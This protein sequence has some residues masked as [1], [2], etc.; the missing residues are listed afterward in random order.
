[1]IIANPIY[2]I[3]FKYL[4]EDLDIVRGL[5]SAILKEEIISLQ[6][7]PQETIMEIADQSI[8]IFK[9][10]FKALIK[11]P[12][13]PPKKV[14]LEL[15]KAKHLFDIMRFRRYLGDNYRKQ[16]PVVNEPESP[17]GPPLEIVTIYFLGFK[18]E[19]VT[20]PVLKVGHR[21]EDAISGQTL[22]GSIRE[23]FVN[24][25][26]HES[27]VIQIPRLEVRLRNHLE[28]VLQVFCQ[29]D[30]MEDEHKIN[31]RQDP[32]NPLA[33]KMVER[34]NRAVSTEEVRRVMDLE[35]DL[36]R[37]FFRLLTEG[38]LKAEKE[39]KEKAEKNTQKLVD[40]A[41]K[42]AKKQAKEEA[43]EEAKKEAKKEVDAAEK[44]A[45][46]AIKANEDAQSKIIELQKRLD[47]LTNKHAI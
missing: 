18:L 15:Q 45:E 47:D 21:Y 40:E 28:E 23:E 4:L 3:V 14:L 42:E 17:Y 39:L 34:L 44:K 16:D 12:S 20:V 37:T 9:L 6:A 25:L 35:D 13:G 22:P 10:D 8:A 1:M 33:K 5:L 32:T 26:T 30:V 43:K 36:E 11:T 46:Q 19:N 29:D 38:I 7:S 24:L 41:K 31:V 27:Y 2:D